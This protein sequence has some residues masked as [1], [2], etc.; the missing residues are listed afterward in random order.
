MIKLSSS[1]FYNSDQQNDLPFFIYTFSVHL[2][3]EAKNKCWTSELATWNRNWASGR[4]PSWLGLKVLSLHD[5]LLTFKFA[6]SRDSWIILIGWKLFLFNSTVSRESWSI[7]I[8]WKLFLFNS[9]V[10][11]V[12]W[13]ILIGLKLFLFKIQIHNLKRFPPDSFSAKYF[14]PNS[15]STTSGN[16]FEVFILKIKIVILLN[17]ITLVHFW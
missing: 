1:L 8:G 17:V 12:S 3:G 11:R 15:K 2:V 7:L 10:S 6:D 14:L 13:S 4:C 16:T 9:T 5:L